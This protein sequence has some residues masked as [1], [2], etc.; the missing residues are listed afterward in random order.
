MSPFYAGPAGRPLQ[1]ALPRVPR[2]RARRGA[3]IKPAQVASRWRSRTA[4]SPAVQTLELDFM[5]QPSVDR[6][7]VRELATSRFVVD[8]DN[9]MLFGSPGVGK[10]HLATTVRCAVV[11]AGHAVRP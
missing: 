3:R 7:L 4:H 2:P 8:P 11:E 5:V 10:T 6:A 1:A 9:V